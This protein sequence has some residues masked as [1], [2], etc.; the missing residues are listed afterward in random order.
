MEQGWR[1]GSLPLS[2]WLSAAAEGLVEFFF[3]YQYPCAPQIGYVGGGDQGP[4][5]HK[6]LLQT[7]QSVYSMILAARQRHLLLILADQ[8]TSTCAWL[9]MCI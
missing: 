3:E 9:H 1:V 8:K 7:Q 4:T 2:M 5:K 6:T